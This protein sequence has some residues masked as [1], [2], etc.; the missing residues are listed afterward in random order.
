MS[1]VNPKIRF[2]TLN[3]KSAITDDI[4]FIVSKYLHQQSL[5]LAFLTETK[6]RLP[7]KIPQNWGNGASFVGIGVAKSVPQNIGGVGFVYREE[8]IKLVPNTLQLESHRYCSAVSSPTAGGCAPFVAL[9]V[10]APTEHHP[11]KARESFF[12][13]LSEYYGKLK[14]QHPSLYIYLA[15]D[16]NTN[17]GLDAKSY[18]AAD[19]V[20]SNA[21]ELSSP[22]ARLVLDFCDHNKLV[23]AN[24]KF[25]NSDRK[26][27]TWNHPGTGVGSVKDLLIVSRNCRKQ[28]AKVTALRRVGAFDHK[29]VL[30]SLLPSHRC[31]QPQ[32]NT[33]PLTTLSTP[34]PNTRNPNA[35]AAKPSKP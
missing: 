7:V 1:L 24:L 23:V 33:R 25:R 14:A 20:L 17:F 30:W 15:G 8:L 18:S 27:E 11:L 9:C 29:A 34:Q 21:P 31:F 5:S 16:F 22:N 4:K 6:I 12:K 2:A 19:Y 13:S 10:Y 35:S 28:L 26:L 32:T 3:V